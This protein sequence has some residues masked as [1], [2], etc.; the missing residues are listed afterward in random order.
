MVNTLVILLQT[1]KYMDTCQ[2]LANPKGNNVI[3]KRSIWN[4]LDEHD[5]G[6]LL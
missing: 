6:M 3:Y 2:V 1:H 5:V 4:R